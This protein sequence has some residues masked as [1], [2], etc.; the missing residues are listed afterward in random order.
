MVT[1]VL[2]FLSKAHSSGIRKVH[3]FCDCCSRQNSNRM[4]YIMLAI[5]LDI[6]DFDEINLCFLVTGHSQN[7]NDTAQSLIA[8]QEK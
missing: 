4:V 3:L 2:K 1:C 7:E 8:L 6:F 5:A